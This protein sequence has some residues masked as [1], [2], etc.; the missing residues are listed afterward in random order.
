MLKLQI[1]LSFCIFY[2]GLKAYLQLLVGFIM[3][4]QIT[5]PQATPLRNTKVSLFN[6]VNS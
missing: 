3:S 1:V 4:Q 5:T 2:S 6:L